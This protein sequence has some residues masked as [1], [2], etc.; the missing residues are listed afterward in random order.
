MASSASWKCRLR[1]TQTAPSLVG[2]MEYWGLC[3]KERAM[4]GGGMVQVKWWSSRWV[5]REGSTSLMFRLG[6]N[7]E[8]GL[9]IRLGE[10]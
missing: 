8:L 5:K 7:G 4:A 3:A 9:E 1:R 2:C 6:G 10:T